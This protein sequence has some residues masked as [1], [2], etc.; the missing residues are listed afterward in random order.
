MDFSGGLVL[1]V[2]P[3]LQRPVE[4]D[5]PGTGTIV[6]A[7]AAIPAFFRMQNNRWLAFL[8]MGYI[9]IYLADFHAVVAAVAYIGIE[10]HRLVRCGD[11]GDSLYFV[12]THLFLRKP[13][14]LRIIALYYLPVYTPV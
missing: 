10:N 11:I 8:R 9:N 4:C 14:C 5:G 3:L 6:N 2:A 13:L 12:F 7:A 1:P